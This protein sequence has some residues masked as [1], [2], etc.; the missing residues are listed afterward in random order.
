MTPALHGYVTRLAKRQVP[1]ALHARVKT[2]L[3]QLA[4]R[5]EFSFSPD[6]LINLALSMV[7]QVGPSPGAT[8]IVGRA[9]TNQAGRE[10]VLR[11]DR[12]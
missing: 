12:R 8:L 10:V 2:L 6:P 5:V 9:L 3:H 11:S 4:T 1:L 7:E